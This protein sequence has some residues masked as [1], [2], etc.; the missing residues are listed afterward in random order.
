MHLDSVSSR[1]RRGRPPLH[2]R[3]LPLAGTRISVGQD[4]DDYR[5]SSLTAPT[6]RALAAMMRARLSA[7]EEGEQALWTTHRFMSAVVLLGDGLP[8]RQPYGLRP[9]GW[10]TE[11]PGLRL[12][13]SG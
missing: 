13:A 7:V 5:V 6:R 12:R 2:M 1:P 9:G 11:G 10:Y 8:R 3:L 4:G